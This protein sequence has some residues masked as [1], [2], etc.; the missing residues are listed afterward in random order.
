MPITSRLTAQGFTTDWAQAIIG[1]ASTGLTAAGTN[2][3]TAYAIVSPFSQ[4]STVAASTGA[5]LPAQCLANDSVAAYNAGANT[6][7]V[8]PPVGG[9][10][11]GG[12][13]NAGVSV[14]TKTLTRFTCI[15]G[16]G[17]D[18]ATG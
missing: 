7:T 15:G 2:Q 8:Y 4:F 10:I 1:D 5:I 13:V 16:A 3:A 12:S 11:N 14:S 17:L 9:T 6:L 18:W